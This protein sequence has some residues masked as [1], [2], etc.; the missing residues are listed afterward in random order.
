MKDIELIDR[1]EKVMK[2]AYPPYSQ[3]SVGAALL[4]ESGN[5]FCGCNIENASY[6]AGI[7]AERTAIGNA[8]ANGEKKFVKLAVVGGKNG[9]ITD[10]CPPCGICRQVLAE[11]CKE[12]FEII[13]Y[14]GKDIKKLTLA[15]ILPL[16]FRSENL[17]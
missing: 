15:E 11:F 4:T 7:C 14:N 1:A 16:S 8:V 9:E 12:D 17:C 2:N 10:F 3:F 13:L 5:V 6:P